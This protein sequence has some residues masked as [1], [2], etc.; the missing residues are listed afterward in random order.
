[1]AKYNK[2][3]LF[4]TFTFRLLICYSQDTVIV[5]PRIHTNYNDS[6]YYTMFGRLQT[7]GFDTIYLRIA[8]D[9][10]NGV[11]YGM[12]TSNCLVDSCL[13]NILCVESK[14]YIC[15]KNR[16][17]F[18]EVNGQR[19]FI[20]KIPKFSKDTIRLKSQKPRKKIDFN[21]CIL[22]VQIREIFFINNANYF[23]LE[24]GD[25]SSAM[26][27]YA[28]FDFKGYYCGDV[29]F[30]PQFLQIMWM[31]LFCEKK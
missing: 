20:L 1:M 3:V 12:Y 18:F 22:Y 31:N 7:G 11:K 2:I 6:N 16:K 21:A 29:Y 8:K 24:I 14:N 4:L 30:D 19:K 28:I 15:V 25:N 23:V 26:P 10:R 13:L 9:A 17:L 27:N 5:K